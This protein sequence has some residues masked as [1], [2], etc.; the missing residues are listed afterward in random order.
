[1]Y[2]VQ[3]P[4]LVKVWRSL[5]HLTSSCRPASLKGFWRTPLSWFNLRYCP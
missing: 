1:M 5:W 4:F 2:Q 3:K